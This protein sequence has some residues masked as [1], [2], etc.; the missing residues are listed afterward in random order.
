MVGAPIQIQT[1]IS[2]GE[3]VLNSLILISLALQRL[4]YVVMTISVSQGLPGLVITGKHYIFEPV[5]VL[6]GSGSWSVT[7]FS[8][9]S[10]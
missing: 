1:I 10:V 7:T 4:I 5:E 9:P 2:L 8:T 3:L 6:V